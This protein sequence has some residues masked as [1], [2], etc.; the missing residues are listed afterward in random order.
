MRLHP[1]RF[2]ISAAHNIPDDARL[3]RRQQWSREKALSWIAPGGR[4][5]ADSPR[6][7]ALSSVSLV[8]L[9]E[10]QGDRVFELYGL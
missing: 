2:L 1:D 7:G 3:I 10:L 6:S 9:G 5:F 8:G 4:R